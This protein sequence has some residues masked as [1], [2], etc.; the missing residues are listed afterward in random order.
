MPKPLKKKRI[1]P[2]DGNQWARHLVD[3][4]TAE[5]EAPA[6]IPPEALSAYMS[7]L[8]RKGGQASGKRRMKNL[9]R[10]QRE[11][12]AAKGGR[13]MWAKRRKSQ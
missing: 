8:G 11:D 13:A 3:K 6:P 12:I 10:E 9:T 1:P 2:Q 4:S 5:P 7:V